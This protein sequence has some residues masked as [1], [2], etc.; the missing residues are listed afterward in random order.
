MRIEVIMAVTTKNTIFWYV[1]SRRVAEEVLPPDDGLIKVETCSV[2]KRKYRL[3]FIYTTSLVLH[4]GTKP[5][6]NQTIRNMTLRYNLFNN[7][8]CCRPAALE[9]SVN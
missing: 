3:Y 2:R 7:P 9:Y 6:I 5:D 4:D 1:M 8:K